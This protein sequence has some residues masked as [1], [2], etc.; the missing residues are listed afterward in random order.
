M[1]FNLTRSSNAVTG[2]TFTSPSNQI[3]LTEAQEWDLMSGK[4]YINI[5][6]GNNGGGEIRG[7]MV[8]EPGSAGL[9]AIGVAGLMAR[10]RNRA[11]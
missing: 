2:G 6:T 7:F 1:V 11:A 9:L 5:H 8:P 4:Y 3:T 10:R